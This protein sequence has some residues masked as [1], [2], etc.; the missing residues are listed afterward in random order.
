MAAHLRHTTR[1]F[2]LDTSV[3]IHDP[4]AV[5]RFKEHNVFIPMI[6]LEELDTLKKGASDLARDARQVS[7]NLEEL[8]GQADQE[9][10]TQGLDLPV[11]KNAGTEYSPGGKLFL[12][13]T[14]DHAPD[15]SKSL[16]G[17]VPD[18][19]ILAATV[20]VTSRYPESEIV[21]VSKDINLRIKSR[22]LGIRAEDYFND[23]ILDDIDLLYTG[24]REVDPQQWSLLISALESKTD[25]VIGNASTTTGVFA[26]TYPNECVF[27]T[28]GGQEMIVR[29]TVDHNLTAA[30][31]TNYLETRHAVWGISARNREQNFAL[32]LLMNPDVD[33][34]SLI[35][36]AGT[37]KTLL[38]LAAGLA[39]SMESKDYLE[40]IMTR[41]TVPVG[42]GIGF[43]PGS[44]EEKMA[45]WMGALA[46][47]LEVLAGSQEGG[48]WGKAATSDLLH[49]KIKLRSLNFMRGRTFNNRYI[50]IDEAQNLTVKQMRTL[51]TRAGPGSKIVCLGNIGQIDSPYLS[52]T[53]SGLTY[54]VDRFKPWAHS[55]H[56]TLTRGERS[57]LADFA[58]REL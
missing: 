44:E 42:E 13:N 10:I 58:T 18:N 2:V 21:L 15:L 17:A 35:G 38:A 19:G 40:I 49:T 36:V 14:F 22:I 53:T 25:R 23:Q 31:A 24:M 39:Q 55:G 48:Q 34:V 9:T 47:N 43:L 45:P 41:E 30:S 54:V 8:L 16:P 3:L 12:E 7:R 57:R 32:N 4:Y 28:D 20:N 1:L 51:I 29:P 27:S 11:I 50:I 46:D 37:G 52:E 6:V 26:Q 33:F 5:Y 56:V